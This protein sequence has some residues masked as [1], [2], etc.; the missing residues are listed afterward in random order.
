MG[1]HFCASSAFSPSKFLANQRSQKSKEKTYPLQRLYI[2]SWVSD[3][4]WFYCVASYKNLCLPFFFV[5]WFSCHASSFLYPCASYFH[6]SNLIFFLWSYYFHFSAHKLNQS[7]FFTLPTHHIQDL[8]C[9][10]WNLTYLHRA[11]CYFMLLWQGLQA[12]VRKMAYVNS[13]FPQDSAPDKHRAEITQKLKRRKEI[14]E[15]I[16]GNTKKKKE[17]R[18]QKIKSSIKTIKK[19]RLAEIIRINS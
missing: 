11:F 4:R 14:Q 13:P 18:I 3:K 2:L 15:N 6:L 7:I 5:S 12:A 8:S 9:L 17:E 19:K 10:E 16:N 1:S